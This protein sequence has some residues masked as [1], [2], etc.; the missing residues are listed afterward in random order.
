MKHT[1]I[2][3]L[4]HYRVFLKILVNKATSGLRRSAEECE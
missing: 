4:R 1:L 2:K 3:I